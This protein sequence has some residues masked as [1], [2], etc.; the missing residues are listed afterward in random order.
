MKCNFSHSNQNKNE[1]L[2]PVFKKSI[3]GFYAQK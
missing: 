1:F 3:G 2:T